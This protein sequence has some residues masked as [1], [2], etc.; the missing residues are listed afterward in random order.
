MRAV[1]RGM[2]LAI[3]ALLI[4]G[5]HAASA[6]R[7]QNR[8]G[9]WFGFGAGYGSLGCDDCDGREG[10]G[11][12]YLKLGGTVSPKVLIGFEAN[13]WVKKED[14]VTLSI[15]NGSAVVYFYP[16][17]AGGFHLKG[18]L[19]LAV[20]RVD[21]DVGGGTFT[22]DDT[23]VGGLLGLGYDARIGRNVSLVPF[24]N[25]LGATFSESGEKSTFNYFQLGL[26]LT[27]H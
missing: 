13:S 21:I 10:S 19:G 23:G 3:L 9:F 11:T 8:K 1:R 2:R 18:G 14:D 16:S 15:S 25:F 6:Q 24:A 22:V 17:A 12:G 27:I 4:G 7:P 5:I 26:G 20:A